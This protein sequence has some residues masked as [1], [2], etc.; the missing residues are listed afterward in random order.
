MIYDPEPGER[1]LISGLD[2]LVL[3]QLSSFDRPNLG[4]PPGVPKVD[5]EQDEDGE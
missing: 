3:A 4:D 5:D 2:A 1:Q